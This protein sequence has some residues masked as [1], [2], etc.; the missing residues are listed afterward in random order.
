MPRESLQPASFPCFLLRP[1]VKSRMLGGRNKAGPGSGPNYTG[2]LEGT[3]GLCQ[4]LSL[5]WVWP[6]RPPSYFQGPFV[7]IVEQRSPSVGPTKETQHSHLDF[8]TGP[9]HMLVKSPWQSFLLLF[10]ASPSEV[11]VFKESCEHSCSVWSTHCK[12]HF[13]PNPATMAN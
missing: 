10:S 1:V 6:K 3:E 5:N 8:S 2:L 4:S 9:Q 11:N 13:P 12:E 7:L